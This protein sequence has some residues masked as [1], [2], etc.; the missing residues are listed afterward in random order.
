MSEQASREMTLHE[1]MC[2]LPTAHDAFQEYDLLLDSLSRLRKERD[3]LQATFDLQYAADLRAIE[4]FKAAHPD[5]PKEQWPDRAA[6]FSWVAADRAETLSERDALRDALREAAEWDCTCGEVND[7]ET[8]CFA[9][10]AR[11]LTTEK[12][13]A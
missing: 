10:H 2:K 13:D 4:M 11:A 9:C 1:W 5:Y 12:P 3:E 7:E 6:L 8:K